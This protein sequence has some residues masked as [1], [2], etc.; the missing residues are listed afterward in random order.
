MSYRRTQNDRPDRTVN[1][2]KL[3][4]HLTISVVTLAP[5]GLFIIAL[6]FLCYHVHNC[7]MRI[8]H[9][10]ATLGIWINYTREVQCYW[11]YSF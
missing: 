6:L 2:L 8:P 3:N 10:P 9:P 5:W 4:S 1:P 11:E 7:I